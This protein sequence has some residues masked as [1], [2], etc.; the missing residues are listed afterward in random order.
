MLCCA[1]CNRDRGNNMIGTRPTWKQAFSTTFHGYAYDEWEFFVHCITKIL[2]F[3]GMSEHRFKQNYP[4]Y[5]P[6]WVTT[7]CKN[8]KNYVG[9]SLLSSWHRLTENIYLSNVND[10]ATNKITLCLCKQL[11]TWMVTRCN[12]N[13]IHVCTLL[14]CTISKITYYGIQGRVV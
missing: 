11:C 9:N 3:R 12:Y 10:F 4:R 5:H 14:H 7:P 6:I 13:K 1:V 2:L 8:G